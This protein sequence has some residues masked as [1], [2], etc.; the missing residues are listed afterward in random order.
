MV[1]ALSNSTYYNSDTPQWPR[2]AFVQKTLGSQRGPAKTHS[3]L[4]GFIHFYFLLYFLARALLHSS[5]WPG[6]RINPDYSAVWCCPVS[7]ILKTRPSTSCSAGKRSANGATPQPFLFIYCW[8]GFA[9]GFLTVRVNIVFEM[10]SLDAKPL[11]Y[12]IVQPYQEGT[13]LPSVGPSSA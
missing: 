9:L 5:G 7:A 4:A 13:D 6:T 10:L 3:C 11:L 2:S 12:N 1:V 8:F